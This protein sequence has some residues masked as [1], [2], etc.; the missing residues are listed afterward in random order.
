MLKYFSSC[1]RWIG[2][3]IFIRWMHWLNWIMKWK[4]FR[5]YK[6]Y[7]FWEIP[8]R[9][10]FVI[11][12]NLIRYLLDLWNSE[13]KT[14]KFGDTVHYFN[15]RSVQKFLCIGNENG[16]KIIFDNDKISNEK[17]LLEVHRPVHETN[18]NDFDKSVI[19]RMKEFVKNGQLDDACKL[20]MCSVWIYSFRKLTKTE[21]G[22]Y[23]HIVYI[24]QLHMQLIG[25]RAF[26]YIYWTLDKRVVVY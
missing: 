26:T 17:H 24:Q 10:N 12:Q 15:V 13:S 25:R 11:R 16:T 4:R 5:I 9:F 3:E 7:P 22:Y 20:H 1:F 19:S 14:F 21:K 6:A 8:K 23:K 18:I 2:I